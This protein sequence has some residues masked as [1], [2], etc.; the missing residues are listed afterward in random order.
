MDASM[1][2]I[3]ACKPAI[4]SNERCGNV[5]Q[6]SPYYGGFR[7][8]IKN[9]KSYRDETLLSPSGPIDALWPYFRH[10]GSELSE[11]IADKKN[12]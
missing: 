11:K 10:I 3:S 6:G 7:F 2:L 12:E 8:L 1:N 5:I 9:Y 4:A